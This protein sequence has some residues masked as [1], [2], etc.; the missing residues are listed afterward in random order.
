MQ[1]NPKDGRQFY[2]LYSALMFYVNGKL[3]VLK[4]PVAD[5]KAFTQL[6]LESM[7]KVR[8][9]FY[10]QPALLDEFLAENPARLKADELEI[11][12]GWKYAIYDQFYIYRYLKR[13]TVFFRSTNDPVKAYGVLGL[14]DPL[15]EVVGPY[16]PILAKA[17][18]LPIKG[19]IIYDGLLYCYS[20]SFGGGYRRMLNDEYKQSKERYGIVTSLPFD[21]NLPSEKTKGKKRKK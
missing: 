3:K 1:I 19:Q 18:L 10:A 5:A 8:D 12:S 4:K 16:L 21:K 6:S 7:H 2:K 20:I 17:V 15:E 13:Y 11:V 9:A 14:A